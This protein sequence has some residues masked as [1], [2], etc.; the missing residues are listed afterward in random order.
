[1][2]VK[3]TEC[4]HSIPDR[5]SYRIIRIVY[6]CEGEGSDDSTEDKNLRALETELEPRIT[7]N[8]CTC[9]EVAEETI[10]KQLVQWSRNWGGRGGHWPPQ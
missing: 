6:K 5:C 10:M 2:H 3:G 8:S 4:F 1:M 7:N 9:G